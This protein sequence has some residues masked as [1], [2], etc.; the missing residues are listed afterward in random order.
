LLKIKFPRDY[1]FKPPC[2]NF[3]TKIFHHNVDCN[4]SISLNLLDYDWSPAITISK[5]LYGIYTLL[6]EP[7]ADYPYDEIIANLYKSDK[8]EFEKVAREYTLKYATQT[9]Q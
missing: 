7:N 5:V 1:P 9:F 4:G 6:S 8:S 3:I 2:I